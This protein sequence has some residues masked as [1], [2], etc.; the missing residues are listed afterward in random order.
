M[1]E[2]RAASSRWGLWI[3]LVLVAAATIAI[4]E[5]DSGISAWFGTRGI[6]KNPLE[7]PLIA[8]ALG[9]LVNVL[10]KA[11]KTHVLLQPAMRTELFL[12]VGLVLMGARLDVTQVLSQG[13]GGVIQ[14]LVMVTCVF[15][16]TWWLGTKLKIGEQLKAVM[17][18]AVS[19]CGVSA[20]IAAAG[21]VVAKKKEIT[22]VTALVIVTAIPLM[23]LMPWIATGIGLPA[24]VAG[25]WFGG[26][27][28]TTAA[29]VGA[30]TIH[31]EEAQA[32]ATVVK[33]SQNA[34]IGV[35]AFLLALY[36]VV[37]VEK[38]PTERPSAAMIWKRFPKFV[39]GFVLVSVLASFGLFNAEVVGALKTLS[40]WAFA[41][42]FFSIGLELSVRELGKMGWRPLAVYGAATVFNTLLA[43][44]VAWIVFGALGF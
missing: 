40:K 28:D 4:A 38:K 36:F 29:V 14:G 32:V 2:G 25:A 26:N 8:V 9:L 37:R 23:V 10:L 13:L 41:M 21:A 1:S 42:A 43:L 39:L 35:A 12:K 16:F 44:G 19:I 33:M 6:A 11:T 7:Y 5:L 3:G 31:G 24:D 27:I 18:A 34:L 30:G 17:A 15:F 20:A 22:Y